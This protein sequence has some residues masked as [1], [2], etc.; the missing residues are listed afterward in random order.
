M[1]KITRKKCLTFGTILVT[2]PIMLELV[3]GGV[4][5]FNQFGDVADNAVAILTIFLVGC[6]SVLLM[7][8]FTFNWRTVTKPIIYKSSVILVGSVILTGL[9]LYLWFASIFFNLSDL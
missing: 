9:F 5:L 3:G 2:L 6:G 4:Y 8:G 1:Y 7:W